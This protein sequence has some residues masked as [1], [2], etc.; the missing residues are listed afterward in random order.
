M[1][2]AMSTSVRR[3]GGIL[4]LGLILWHSPLPDQTL[5][6]TPLLALKEA[7][8]CAGCHNPGRSQRP[9]LERRCTLDCQGCHV[10]PA[11]AG[12]RNQWGYYYS[13]DQLAAVKL[14]KPQDPLK[15]TS[16]I[17]LHYDGRLIS[18]NISGGDSRL[19]PMSNE[20]SV[21]VRPFVN[22]LHLT[23]QNML[24]GRIDDD[25]FRINSEGDR[26]FR[27]KYSVMIDALP[28]NTYVRWYRGQ[29]MYGLQRPN[30]S[31]W[32]RERIGLDQF[33]T[34]EAYEIGLTPNVPFFR[35]SQMA[36][37][38]YVAESEKQK[39]YSFHGGLRG[40]S[41]AWHLNSSFWDTKSESTRIRMQAIGGGFNL[42]KT[43]VYGERNWRSVSGESTTASTT[44]GNPMHRGIHPSSTI[45]EWSIAYAGLPG[46]NGGLMYEKLAQ[47]D[48]ESTRRSIF[49]DVHPVPFVQLEFWRR[50]EAGATTLA[51][52]LAV[53]HLY[54][55]F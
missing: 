2:R 29:P 24:L 5:Q 17:D 37:D 10:D 25:V 44:T 13:Q 30:H 55:D 12:P 32:I 28:L 46:I 49:I 39:G 3:A 41:F 16:R 7:E 35:F 4:C 51:D 50:Y 9:V 31:L 27:E 19:F 22:Y 11:G 53:M 20:F 40:V 48:V 23:Y 18:R 34:T 8:N 38:P 1:A 42:F 21:R 6:A 36:G 47:R 26:R 15:D 43:I 54:A 45:E 33:A 14:F 52:T